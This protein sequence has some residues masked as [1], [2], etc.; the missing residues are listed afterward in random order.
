MMLCNGSLMWYWRMR[1]PAHCFDKGFNVSIAESS[2]VV[3]GYAA[4]K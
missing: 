4:R 2:N 3:S 1:P